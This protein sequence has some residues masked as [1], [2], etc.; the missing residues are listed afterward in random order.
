MF[1]IVA[2]FIERYIFGAEA[3]GN[4]G[5]M[6]DRRGGRLGLVLG[7]SHQMRRKP[8]RLCMLL[9]SAK[10]LLPRLHC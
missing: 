10:E 8:P 4:R 7:C 6:Q 5:E 3:A 9:S 1:E 2:I